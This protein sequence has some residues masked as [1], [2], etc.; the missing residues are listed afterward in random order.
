VAFA[1][2]GVTLLYNAVE[3][4]IAIW[5]GLRAES[6]VLLS[7]GADS[8]L[9]VL[10]AAAVI[11]RL[12]YRDAEAGEAAEAKALRLIGATFFALAAAVV[13]QSTVALVQR[14]GA[15]ESLTGVALLIASLIVMPVLA[16]AKLRTA[17]QENLPALAAEAKETVACSY[18]SFTALLGLVA[19][20][21][22]G[23]WWTDPL[24][25]LLMVPWLLKEGREGL[26]GEAC[27]DGASVCWCRGCWYGFRQCTDLV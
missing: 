21:V 7:F 1:L 6:I 14:D 26:R 11:W 4:V 27:F 22:I 5:S 8:Y 23:A 2:L 16:L 24:A 10:A 9:E 25:A 12:S 17:A 20:V 3:G 15:S 19:G 18:L 13:L